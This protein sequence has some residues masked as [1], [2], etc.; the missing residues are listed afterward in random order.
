MSLQILDKSRHFLGVHSPELRL[1]IL[2]MIRKGLVIIKDLEKSRD[3]FIHQVWPIVLN[4]LQD[5][6]H[7]IV[8]ESLLLIAHICHISSDFVYK[9]VSMDLVSRMVHVLQF[10]RLD[11]TDLSL[12]KEYCRHSLAFKNFI[13]SFETMYTLLYP[14]RLDRKDTESLSKALLPYLKP[15]FAKEIQHFAVLILHN[16]MSKDHGDLVWL[17]LWIA[18]GGKQVVHSEFESLQVPTWAQSSCPESFIQGCTQILG[19]DLPPN[20][21]KECHVNGMTWIA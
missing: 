5:P 17:E 15:C 12:N 1:Y 13:Q 21:W 18:I 4:R 16:L 14:M 11:L 10:M 19:I 20:G 6:Q 8:N 9:R 7:Y 3:P 2:Q